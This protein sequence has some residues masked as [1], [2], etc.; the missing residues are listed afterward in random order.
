M[1]TVPTGIKMGEMIKRLFHLSKKP[2]IN[3]LNALYDDNL[4]ETAGVEYGST[5]SNGL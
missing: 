4:E 1:N 2:L 5:V 3:L